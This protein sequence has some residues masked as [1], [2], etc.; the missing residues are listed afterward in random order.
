MIKWRKEWPNKK[1]DCMKSQKKSI[2]TWQK[3]IDF[4]IAFFVCLHI[5]VSVYLPFLCVCTLFACCVSFGMGV[6][7]FLYFYLCVYKLFMGD[8]RLRVRLRLYSCVGLCAIIY[9]CV[10]MCV[11]VCPPIKYAC[12]FNPTGWR[13]LH[14]NSKFPELV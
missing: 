12:T 4:L 14:K 10:Y 3:L 2:Q 9:A 6:Y 13:S 8:S 11:C 5:Y 7:A 1:T